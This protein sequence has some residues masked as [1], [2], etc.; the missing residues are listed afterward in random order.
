MQAN[1]ND[2]TMPLDEFLKYY[3]IELLENGLYS[4]LSSSE[5]AARK[6]KKA[7]NLSKIHHESI[8]HMVIKILCEP[9]NIVLI[10]VSITLLMV[11]LISKE[12][13]EHLNVCIF[14][15][16]IMIVNILIEIRNHSKLKSFYYNNQLKY[17]CRVFRDGRLSILQREELVVGD[18]ISLYKHDIV[19]ADCRIIQCDNLVVNE[20]VNQNNHEPVKKTTE[21]NCCSLL[22][23][24]TI[25][26]GHAI[27][28]V[29]EVGK[30]TMYYKKSSNS[31]EV[32]DAVPI[33][34]KELD[35]FFWYS[36][37]FATILSIIFIVP[38][39]WLN[40]T[41]LQLIVAVVTTYISFLPEGIP[42]LVKLLL[43]T[44]VTKLKKESVFVRDFE[45]LEK[46]GE[47]TT[48]CI[49]KSVIIQSNLQMAEL[50][51]DGY[52]I[53]DVEIAFTDKDEMNLECIKY[54]GR[55]CAFIGFRMENILP[56]NI[57]N[58]TV[59]KNGT[60][61][62]YKI[63][64]P[65]PNDELIPV[66]IDKQVNGINNRN[67]NLHLNASDITYSN[68]HSNSE[69][70]KLQDSL[71]LFGKICQEYFAVLNN[72]KLKIKDF[73]V[74]TIHGAILNRGK[75]YRALIAGSPN[76]VLDNCNSISKKRKTKRLS[77]NKK[78]KL[79]NTLKELELLGYEVLAL[80]KK[81]CLK[82]IKY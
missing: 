57:D 13:R 48:M 9:I 12:E 6:K 21:I 35:S 34:Y 20:Y 63:R 33:L 68:L 4:G 39:I 70:K 2:Y 66:I 17:W 28:V 77:S 27:A 42:A 40:I 24:S 26:S 46:L 44:A 62:H 37:G 52:K 60:K 5:A 54:I 16:I 71:F 45:S 14:T 1:W 53:R 7:N 41:Y 31:I 75:K 61:R 29:V 80:A 58:Y 50:I 67:N 55:I 78:L 72:Y 30:D 82:K 56:K 79:L 81:L 32:R 18:I 76:E 22:S 51:Y 8:M 74:G 69:A 11:Y 47:I 10:I 23:S 38:G 19:G 59:N 15:I 36:F 73:H 43:Y 25:L 64:I 65:K 49:E 3:N